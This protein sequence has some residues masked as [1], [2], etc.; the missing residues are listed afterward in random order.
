MKNLSLNFYGEKLSIKFPKDFISLKKEI[1]E[2]YQISLSDIFEM[3]IS[4]IKDYVKKIIKTEDDFK[5]FLQS[6]IP[7]ISLDI[8][9]SSKLF[10]SGL[11]NLQ[12]KAKDDL[13]NLER[14]KLKKKESKQKQEKE[15]E[16]RKKKI[17]D[18]KDQIKKLEKKKQ[19][20]VKSLKEVDK[21]QR[22][23]EKE[24]ISKITKLSKKTGA[25]LVFKITEEIKGETE[26][27]KQLF[28]LI[29]KYNE[30]I[31][32]QREISSN[33]RKNISIIDKQIKELNK[34]CFRCVKNS[35]NA[36]FGLK[37]EEDNTAKEI[38]L[39]E[40]KK[41]NEKKERNERIK[42]QKKDFK[43]SLP[44]KNEKEKRKV[45]RKIEN[46]VKNLRKNI[47]D[48]VEKQIMRT[49]KKIEKI[50]E[51]AKENKCLLKD[52]D[53][54]YLKKCKQ[55]NDKASKEVDKWIEYIFI[56]SHELIEEIEKNN[57][58]NLKNFDNLDKK[59]ELNSFELFLRQD[60]N[61]NNIGATMPYIRYD[62][63]EASL[64]GG[65]ILIT[66]PNHS[67]DNIASQSSK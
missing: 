45:N 34:N 66:S 3:D 31:D 58:V 62:S 44:L 55:E 46:L 49:N 63:E 13:N 35:E 27:E 30:L 64:G 33:P 47:K 26:N 18:L 22:D 41:K 15:F 56:H 9:E 37:Q 16:E 7:N 1:S 29:K 19:E 52:E 54:K 50:L 40:Q 25:P 23:Q 32:I 51:K 17:N 38:N 65:A 36:I 21:T 12:K 8:N 11:L 67:Q 48:D 42:N 61:D 2:K 57:E 24:L 39:L 60:L 20:Y 59:L 4:Y 6:G 53:E 10:Q 43:L 28:E 5:I 14:L